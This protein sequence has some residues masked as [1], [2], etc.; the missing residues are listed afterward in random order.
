MTFPIPELFLGWKSFMCVFT[1]C[2]GS[3]SRMYTLT[4]QLSKAAF[5]KTQCNPQ[6]RGRYIQTWNLSPLFCAK[7][8]RGWELPG[9]PFVLARSTPQAFMHLQF[10]CLL[11]SVP[12]TF[13][14]SG[15]L[16]QCS[17]WGCLLR[18]WKIQLFKVRT[19]WDFTGGPVATTP[20]SEYRGPWSLPG[21][22]TRF[23]VQQ[24]KFQ[25]AATQ[26]RCSQII[27]I[28]I[29]FIKGEGLHPFQT[30]ALGTLLISE[31]LDRMV[32]RWNTMVGIGQALHRC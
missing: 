29:F 26:I 3:Y 2:F 17:Q 21:Q 6:D 31:S 16:S 28:Y 10:S 4:P 22:G 23:H 8:D 14:Q 15:F 27:N 7:T 13:L 24:L 18:G 9:R 1:V 19:C 12:L 5:T 32:E 30:V 11:F 20:C 25:Q